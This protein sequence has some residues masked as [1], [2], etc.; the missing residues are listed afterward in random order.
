MAEIIKDGVGKG[1]YAKVDS[2]NRLH[3]DSS[4]LPRSAVAAFNGD[5][6]NINT[7]TINLTGTSDSGLLYV[8]N[9][10]DN[11]I[12][13]ETFIYLLGNTD[14]SGDTQVQ[15]IRNPTTGT[16]ITGGTAFSAV[17]RNF[18]TSKTL[19]ATI[20]KGAHGTTVTDGDVAIESIFSGVGRQVVS[21]G[22]V[23]L[24]KNNSVAIKVQAP[25]GTTDMDVQLAISCYEEREF[26][27]G[28][29]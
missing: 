2:T 26:V 29:N 17:N 4:Q 22:A 9:T 28:T 7:G 20:L 11:S 23:V 16:L 1:F 18:N 21:V 24:N 14:G 10:G 3:T 6:Y 27:N 8:K 12:V 15:I 13:I 5:A 25:T 19:S